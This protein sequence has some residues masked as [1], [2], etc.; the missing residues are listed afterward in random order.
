ML[1]IGDLVEIIDAGLGMTPTLEANLGH[2]GRIIDYELDSLWGPR[3]TVEGAMSAI[4]PGKLGAFPEVE[5]RRIPPD[6]QT[7]TWSEVEVL[8]NWNPIRENSNA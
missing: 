4:F 7:T 6:Q 3:Y 2:R 5:L 8:T 1:N